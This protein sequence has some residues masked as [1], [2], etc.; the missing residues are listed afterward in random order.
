LV[1]PTSPISGPASGFDAEHNAVAPV[2]DVETVTIPGVDLV[3]F[4][5]VAR[6][7]RWS[8]NNVKILDQG[9]VVFDTAA[10]QTIG[11]QLL[12]GMLK[13]IDLICRFYD[14]LYSCCSFSVIIS[15]VGSQG[16][17]RTGSDQIIF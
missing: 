8:R 12:E 10:D 9:M 5:V 7:A 1:R 11:S 16:R 15:L 4:P 3:K 14:S 17:C 13:N 2:Q 6:L